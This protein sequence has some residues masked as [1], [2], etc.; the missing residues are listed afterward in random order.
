MKNLLITKNKR[1]KEELKRVKEINE[2][3]RITILMASKM[4]EDFEKGLHD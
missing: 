3:G 1:K 2:V 4:L